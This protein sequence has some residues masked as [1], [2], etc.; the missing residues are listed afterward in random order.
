MS[1]CV[2]KRL[3]FSLTTIALDV[4]GGGAVELLELEATNEPI[5]CPGDKGWLPEKIAV[6]LE[7]DAACPSAPSH[8]TEFSV[9]P[10]AF[11]FAANQFELPNNEGLPALPHRLFTYA[12]CQ[13]EPPMNCPC[14]IGFVLVPCVLAAAA[15]ALSRPVGRHTPT[16][17]HCPG[18]CPKLQG[19]GA[20]S[21]PPCW[22]TGT[23]WN[24]PGALPMFWF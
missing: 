14:H 20:K 21:D 8:Q 15:A 22:P 19:T 13:L 5:L 9:L 7:E 1:S 17:C 12:P 18:C 2:F 11:M 6:E 16:H 4:T 24:D 23:L 10:C 3:R